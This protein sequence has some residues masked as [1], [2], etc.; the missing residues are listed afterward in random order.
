MRGRYPQVIDQVLDMLS[1][2]VTAALLC[3]QDKW[4]PWRALASRYLIKQ[5][6]LGKQA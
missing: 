2:P 4:L 1:H 6:C 3:L 5:R